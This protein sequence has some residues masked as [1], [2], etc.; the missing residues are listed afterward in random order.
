MLGTKPSHLMDFLTKLTTNYGI[1]FLNQDNADY[2][3]AKDIFARC[4]ELNWSLFEFNKRLN[5]FLD[6]NK[7]FNFT[8]ADFINIQ[9]EQL[10]PHSWYIEEVTKNPSAKFEAYY[11]NGDIM[12]RFKKNRPIK[13]LTPVEWFNG[14]QII[15]E[16]HR[17][18]QSE[19]DAIET[20]KK[21]S[22]LCKKYNFK[23]PFDN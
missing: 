11:V 8:R 20:M 10:Y 13:G 19:S 23:N 17:L 3:R 9:R 2:Q 15:S 21:V 22:E 18:E 12:Y 7:W 1:D 4:T 16:S 14:G 5:E 6:T